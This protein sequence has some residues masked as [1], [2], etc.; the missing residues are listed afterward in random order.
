MATSAHRLPVE[1]LLNIFDQVKDT[2]QL[3]QC[4]LVCK[5]WAPLVEMAMLK[6]VVLDEHNTPKLYQHLLKNPKS[7]RYIHKISV[8]AFCPSTLQNFWDLL[9]LAM[10]PNLRAIKGITW[11]EEDI[12]LLIRTAAQKSLKHFKLEQIP[13]CA[14]VTDMYVALQRLLSTTLKTVWI[15]LFPKTTLDTIVKITSHLDQYKSL[16]NFELF[17]LKGHFDSI[18]KLDDVL[19]QCVRLKSIHLEMDL[20]VVRSTEPDLDVWLLQNVQKVESMESVFV[21]FNGYE[22]NQGEPQDNLSNSRIL[23]L[24]YLSS[25]YP[26][27]K[28]VTIENYKQR[29]L[30]AARPVFENAETVHLQDWFMHSVDQVQQIIHAWRSQSNSIAIRYGNSTSF[31]D[32]LCKIDVDK[33]K[34]TNH[35][36]F[37]LSEVSWHHL[38]EEVAKQLISSLGDSLTKNFEIDLVKYQQDTNR[39]ISPLDFLRVAPAIESCKIATMCVLSAESPLTPFTRLHTLEVADIGLG[40]SDVNHILEWTP[41]LKHLAITSCEFVRYPDMHC[42]Q[43][44][45]LPQ[46]DLSTLTLDGFIHSE[47]YFLSITM[48]R[49]QLQQYFF[50]QSLC[51][52]Q[53]TTFEEYDMYHECTAVIAITCN[54]LGLLHVDLSGDAQ[55]TMEFDENGNVVKLNH[56]I[57]DSAMTLLKKENVSLKEE[58]QAMSLKYEQAKKHLTEAQIQAIENQDM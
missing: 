50:V 38:S 28:H 9:A 25:K 2:Q 32:Y 52:I 7:S 19:K 12:Y 37:T 58:V 14:S 33:V 24:R 41:H 20:F 21:R 11:P 56:C 15:G 26:K 31:S 51:P 48:A 40:F 22:P 6:T 57:V 1:V 29:Y 18:Q 42:E 3:T 8:L 10:T 23:L 27:A 36:Q 53:Q 54:S 17:D 13:T 43:K 4:K 47:S 16:T 34:G 49:F 44:L 5:M 39:T 46:L 45:Y 30:P 55:S 35:T